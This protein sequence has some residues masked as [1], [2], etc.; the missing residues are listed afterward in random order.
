M[1]SIPGNMLGPYGPWAAAA[2]EAS[3]LEHP[4][5]LSFRNERWRSIDEWKQAARARLAEL[6][7]GPQ[8]DAPVKPRVLRQLRVDSLEGEHHAGQAVGRP[9]AGTAGADRVEAPP[10]Q[11]RRRLPLHPH[12]RR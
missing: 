7:A 9:P 6:L 4:G 12:R 5:P 11:G 2:L 1:P 10:L 3:S 8:V